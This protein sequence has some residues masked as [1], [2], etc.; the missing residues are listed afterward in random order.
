MG[1]NAWWDSE[2]NMKRSSIKKK[3][4]KWKE[5]NGGKGTY[6]KERAEF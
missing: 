1:V 5:V 3:L 6:L 4:K 2:C